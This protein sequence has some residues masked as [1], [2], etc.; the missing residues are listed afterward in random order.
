[1]IPPVPTRI[2]SWQ[3]QRVAARR[4]STRIAMV[5]ALF[6]GWLA[7][8]EVQVLPVGPAEAILADLD[9]AHWHA[10]VVWRDDLPALRAHEDY[11]LV[12]GGYFEE[13]RSPSALLIAAG[14]SPV[15]GAPTSPT[16]ASWPWPGARSTCA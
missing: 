8:A 13:D 15:A 9:S 10:Q 4:R 2:R 14:K 1:M 3:D 6:P 16:R 11:V 12:N 7:S 5:T